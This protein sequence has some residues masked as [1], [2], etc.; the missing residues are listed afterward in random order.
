MRE[1]ILV[2]AAVIF[3][4]GAAQLAG[5]AI[6]FIGQLTGALAVAAFLYVPSR[7][8]ERRREDATDAGLRFDRL[9]ADLAWSLGT[10]AVILPLFALAFMGFG[11]LPPA[12]RAWLTPYAGAPRWHPVPI[13][14]DLAGAIAGNAA[15]ALSEEFFYRGYMTMRFEEKT[16]PVRA[17]LLAALLFALGH[18][19]S[20][21]PFRLAVFFP[22]LW[23]A[24]LR[25]RTGTVVGASIAHW[26]ANVA[27]LCL[28][29]AA[30]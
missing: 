17:A 30:Y 28:E 11:H 29:R 22:A 2:W 16:T 4:L 26:L 3:T 18:L 15:V 1:P 5:L 6:P 27:L 7:M 8:L 9:P 20:P 24:F 10:S 14:F 19:L 25:H 21:A 23:F 13:T 12:A